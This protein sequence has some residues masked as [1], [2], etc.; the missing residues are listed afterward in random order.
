MTVPQLIDRTKML[1]DILNKQLFDGELPEVYIDCRNIDN[2]TDICALALCTRISDPSRCLFGYTNCDY[3]ILLGTRMAETV[4]DPHNEGR[5]VFEICDTLLHEM[6][7]LYCFVK[8]IDQGEDCHSLG[9]REAALSH[10]LHCEKGDS[11]YNATKIEDLKYIAVINALP[12]W[13][14][15]DFLGEGE[16]AGE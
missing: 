7:H 13:M 12:F 4:F 3:A 6:I 14:L 9:F 11:G 8:G 16:E 5:E 15:E 2:L 10:G 1:F